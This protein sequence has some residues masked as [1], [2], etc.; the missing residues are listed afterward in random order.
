LSTST[1]E[2]GDAWLQPAE[3]FQSL[4][5][6]APVAYHEIDTQGVVRRVNRT[7]CE[8]LGFSRDEMLGR[9]IWRYLVSDDQNASQER[10]RSKMKRAG[11]IPPSERVFVRRDGITVTLEVHENHILDSAGSVI[12]IRTTML[13]I[14]ARKRAERAEEGLRRI[15][16][17]HR[18]F[19]EEDVA[20]NYIAAPDG[21]ILECNPAFLLLFG[22]NSVD[23][24]LATTI[25]SLYP[26]PDAWRVFLKT[27]QENRLLR[28][29]NV[30]LRRRNGGAIQV[31][32]NVVGAFNERGEL[33]EIRGHVIDDTER[34]LSEEALARKTAELARSNKELELF[35]YVASH[36]LQEPLRMVS[37]YT[38][39]LARRYRGRLGSDADEF[40]EFAVD[41]AKRM[42]TLINDLLAYARVGTRGGEF[43]VTSAAAA[44]EMAVKNLRAAVEDSR[45][46][47]HCGTLPT[48]FADPLQFGQLFQNLIG[49]AIKY[50][51]M[52]PPEIRITCDELAGDWRFLVQDNGIGIDP[53]YADRIFQIFQRL[54]NQ[55]E[56]S[57]TGIGLAICK[58]IVER[59]G[60]RIWVES[61]PEQGSSFFFTVPKNGG[62]HA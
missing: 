53:K 23:E 19:F 44:V 52:A 50:R 34:K 12:G 35:A 47:V 9:P 5:E 61:Q 46:S 4:F 6:D 27:L 25:A 54:H 20:A 2:T 32:Q 29:S 41:G 1:L 36:D 15:E 40:I 21:Q 60:G 10:I 62:T 58:K 11:P 24:A 16:N 14:T 43:K 33:V 48:L 31:I 57:G 17:K 3:E 7:E 49:N 42:Q 51:Q 30:E 38:Q 18:R 39:L 37:S 8:L 28:Y 13:D 55:K 45:A 56:Y 26:H 59:H 22:F